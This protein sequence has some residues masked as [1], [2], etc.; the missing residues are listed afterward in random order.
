MNR[1]NAGCEYPLCRIYDVKG[2]M[3]LYVWKLSGDDRHRLRK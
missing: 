2:E 3:S 1:M